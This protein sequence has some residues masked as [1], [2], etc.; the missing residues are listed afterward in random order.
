[1]PLPAVK[2]SGKPLSIGLEDR[3]KCIS[4]REDCKKKA[5]WLLGRL[6]KLLLEDGR[7]PQTLKVFIRDFEKDKNDPKRKFAKHSR[8][9]KVRWF[10]ISKIKVDNHSLAKK[11]YIT[12]FPFWK[13][14]M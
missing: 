7:K 5:T 10:Y 8:Q 2:L 9:C 12:N 4:S 14:V 3:F 13:L 11:V 6:A 1:M